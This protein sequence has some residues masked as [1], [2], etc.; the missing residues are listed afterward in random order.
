[1]KRKPT[2]GP[3]GLLAATAIGVTAAPAPEEAGVVTPHSEGLHGYIGLATTGPR[4][5]PD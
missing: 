4:L 5:D 2:K 3:C 1:M